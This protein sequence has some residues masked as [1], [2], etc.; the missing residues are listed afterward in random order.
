MLSDKVS[1]KVAALVRDGEELSNDELMSLVYDTHLSRADGIEA[2]V[3]T[4]GGRTLILA[5]A[6]APLR[7]RFSV[8]MRYKRNGGRR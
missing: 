6:A 7:D 1:D 4:Y 2:D 8:S 3:F 5:Y